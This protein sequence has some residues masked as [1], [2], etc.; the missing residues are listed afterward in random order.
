VKGLHSLRDFES[1]LKNLDRYLKQTKM[2]FF[3]FF[4]KSENRRVEPFLWGRGLEPM[5]EG[6]RW[7]K[8]MAR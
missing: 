8:G 1:S 5:G 6:R 4:T 7:G 3:F 2:S